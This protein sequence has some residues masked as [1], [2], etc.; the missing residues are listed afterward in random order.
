MRPSSD[1]AK[2]SSCARRRLRRLRG[3]LVQHNAIVN[4]VELDRTV[5]YIVLEAVNT[6]TNFSR[7][8]YLSFLAEPRRRVGTRVKIRNLSA[9]TPGDMLL[10]AARACRG[11]L[12]APPS[13]RRSEPDWKDPTM[14]FRACQAVSPTHLIDVQNALSLQTRVFVD[15]PTFRNFYAHRNDE[16]ANRAVQLARRHYLIGGVRHPTAALLAIRHARPQSLLLDW[17]DEMEVVIEVLCD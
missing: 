2:L 17:L 13:D 12:A 1:L 7:S 16:T 5:A 4:S 3:P 6:W 15:M 9:A 8:Y 10:L 14:L 11:P